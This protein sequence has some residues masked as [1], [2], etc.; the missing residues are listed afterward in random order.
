MRCSLHAHR[1]TQ[2]DGSLAA[3]GL[4]ILERTCEEGATD[5]TGTGV[6]LR[7]TQQ[8]VL[9]VAS[10]PLT[11]EHWRPLAEGEVLAIEN[12]RLLLSRL[13]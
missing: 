11:D 3:P 2:A 5:L 13:G 1:R 4:H 8:T 6:P 7:S 12:D 9:L 10:V